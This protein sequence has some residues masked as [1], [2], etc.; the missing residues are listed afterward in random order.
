MGR[1][2]DVNLHLL[3]LTVGDGDRTKR[4]ARYAWMARHVSTT[5]GVR[6]HRYHEVRC[7]PARQKFVAVEEQDKSHL[8]LRGSLHCVCGTYLMFCV[9]VLW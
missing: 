7:G 9:Y 5:D 2:W 1:H 6:D 8:K 4:G 3:L